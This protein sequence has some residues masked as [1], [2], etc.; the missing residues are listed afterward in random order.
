[1]VY[2]TCGMRKDLVAVKLGGSGK[3]PPSAIAWRTAD[4]TPDTPC[5][6]VT[7][8]LLFL[9][10]DGGIAQCFDA[11]TGEAKWKQRL[12]GDHKASPLAAPGRVYFLSRNGRCAVVAAAAPFKKLADNRLDDEFIAS[13]AV[14]DGKLYLRGRNA[15]Y[16]IGKTDN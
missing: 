8:G 10:S 13:P 7:N 1:M 16:C 3:L 9:V 2:A 6:V 11:L 5:P 15:L 12:P 14:S 4:G